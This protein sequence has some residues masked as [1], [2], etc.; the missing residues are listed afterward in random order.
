MPEPS[1][2][3]RKLQIRSGMRVRLVD[4]PGDLAGRLEPLPDGA[5]VVDMPD[6]ADAVLMFVRDRAGLAA[7]S[8]DVDT[9]QDATLLWIAY[10]KGSSGVPS[11][12]TRDRGWEPVGDA[13]FDPVS[14][15]SIDETWSAIRF[16]RDPALRAKRAAEGRFAPGMRRP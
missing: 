6:D 15:V 4:P 14:Q 1:A 5:R 3:S 2:L 7:R 9:L 10:P 13:G 12:L 16:R 8:P 11:D